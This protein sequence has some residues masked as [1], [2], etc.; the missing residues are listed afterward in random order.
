[1]ILLILAQFVGDSW[2]RRPPV[3]I[4]FWVA[5]EP[6]WATAYAHILTIHPG[7]APPPVGS[8]WQILQLPRQGLEQLSLRAPGFHDRVIAKQ[9]VTNGRYPVTGV[10]SLKPRWFWLPWLLRPGYTL[11]LLGLMAWGWRRHRLGLRERR[12]ETAFQQGKALP[13]QQIG[14]YVVDATL[15]QGGMARVYRVHLQDDER[16]RRAL[17]LLNA[18]G[19]GERFQREARLSVK[20]RHPHLVAFYDYGLYRE[21]AYLVMELVEGQTLDRT[22]ANLAARLT[23]LSQVC[24]ALQV[25]HDQGIVHRDVKP[26][27]IMVSGAKALLMDFGIARELDAQELTLPGQAVGTPGYM[28]P[29]QILGQ[30][31]DIRA[32]LYS[33]GVVLYECCCGSLPYQAETSFEL[34]TKQ[35]EQEPK[36]LESGPFELRALVMR[37]LSRD[38]AAR[39]GP[40]GELA[41]QLAEWS[42]RLQAG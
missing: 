11:G 2:M 6:P 3:G 10:V 25:L 42:Q 14:P 17:K 31:L 28:A 21:R 1:M 7:Q 36:P 19:S 22:G 9:D 23:Y 30:A 39:P 5:S 37:L 26:S 12:L 4:G 15:G 29:E 38:P 24:Q 18:P 20:L 34:I 33:L 13:G 16:E 32:D 35:L 27:N 40:A 41:R 8:G